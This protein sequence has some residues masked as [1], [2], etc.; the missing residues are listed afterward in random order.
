[1]FLWARNETNIG[2]SA[3]SGES[4][5]FNPNIFMQTYRPTG[6]DVIVEDVENMNI[7]LDMVEKINALL[8][9]R[10]YEGAMADP[11]G[12]NSGSG[13]AGGQAAGATSGWGRRSQS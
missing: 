7:A 1:M 2:I 4:R 13:A 11:R 10:N 9:M 6:H 12:P 8:V 5:R 3:R